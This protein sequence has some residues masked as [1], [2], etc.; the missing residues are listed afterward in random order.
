MICDNCG[1]EFNEE[2][3]REEFEFETV[4]NY[5]FLTRNLCAKCAIDVFESEIDG[6]YEEECYQCGKKFDP[7]EDKCEFFSIQSYIEDRLITTYEEES[8]NG[9][10]CLECVEKKLEDEIEW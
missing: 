3:A 4:K 8:D 7:F 1:K 5:D 9:T 2:Q 6:E 10:L